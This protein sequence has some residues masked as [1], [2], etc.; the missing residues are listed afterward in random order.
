VLQIL[1]VSAQA[2]ENYIPVEQARP[3][4]LQPLPSNGKSKGS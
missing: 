2:K 3:T 4:T 1:T